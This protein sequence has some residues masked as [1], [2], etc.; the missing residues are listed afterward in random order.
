MSPLTTGVDVLIEV[1][2]LVRGIPIAAMA[3]GDIHRMC[4][5][6]TRGFILD[7]IRNWVTD[8]AAPQIFLLTDAAGYGKSTIAKQIATELATDQRL[9][10]RFFFS[11][12]AEETRTTRY[13]FSTIAQQG[14]CRFDP[15]LK[16]AVAIGIKTLINP[17]SALL[18]EQ[19]QELFVTPLEN[20]KREG[21]LILDALD[22]CETSL[23]DSAQSP[24][25]LILSS[26]PNIPNLKVFITCRPEAEL[27]S[28]LTNSR[29]TRQVVSSSSNRQSNMDDIETFLIDELKRSENQLNKNDITALVKQADGL[30]IWATTAAKM[31]LR[32]GL[33][34]QRKL[35][36]LLD[37]QY[38][39]LD[40]LYRDVLEA[41]IS[42]YEMEDAIKI[43]EIVAI[44]AEPLSPSSIDQLLEHSGS[45]LLIQRMASVLLCE[46]PDDLIRFLHPTFQE[47]LL[48]SKRSGQYAIDS[49]SA[50]QSMFDRT[51][52]SLH[53]ELKYDICQITGT[54]IPVPMNNDI[55]DL[56]G[57]IQTNIST[58]L[59]YSSLHW[60]THAS[61]VLENKDVCTDMIH[62]FL[63]KLLNWIEIVGLMHLIIPCIANIGQLIDAIR[64]RAENM[65]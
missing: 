56:D 27:V 10:G 20:M 1:E 6:G 54:G 25:T 43:L 53:K 5:K 41:A 62:F 59:Q 36:I 7:D 32:R 34:R 37:P 13:L 14:I 45:F 48:Q 63:E 29:H 11:R 17:A 44:G 65:V 3:N 61:N 9:L 24:L 57:L 64:N 33:S 55:P 21:V 18:E 12:S 26:L 28:S 52:R 38:K 30:F 35:D 58:A 4:T 8:E 31:L 60:I 51:M 46:N 16:P 2:S 47:F 50:H 42:E 15:A 40:A 49:R 19:F 39:E 22:E 23:W